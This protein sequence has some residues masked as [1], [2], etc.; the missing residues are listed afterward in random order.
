MV[1]GFVKEYKKKSLLSALTPFFRGRIKYVTI[2]LLVAAASIPVVFSSDIF[3]KI[4]ETPPVAAALRA[5]GLG[6]FVSAANAG[7]SREFVK[8]V[9]DKAEADSARDSYRNKL[10]GALKPAPPCGSGCSDVSTLTMIKG[11][12]DIYNSEVGKAGKKYAASEDGTGAV[13]LKGE[14]DGDPRAGLGPYVNR[15]LVSNPAS[16]GDR[17]AGI[18][19][20]AINQAGGSIP[21]PGR[22]EK[23]PVKMQGRVSGFS[24]KDVRRKS[25]AGE[26][27]FGGKRPM[28]QLAETFSA[29]DFAVRSGNSA[30]ERKASY[31][32]AAYDGNYVKLGGMR[33]DAVSSVP[34]EGFVKTL[35]DD[36]AGQQL[37][38]DCARARSVQGEKISADAKEMDSL[39]QAG[40]PP[41][42]YGDIDPW[43]ARVAR[44][45][46]LCKDFNY[47]QSILARAC[48]ISEA[49][50][51]CGVYFKND[52]N[53][54]RIISKCDKP[55]IIIRMLMLLR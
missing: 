19:A 50:M 47:N 33:T 21:V 29:G 39:A 11:A 14:P 6:R 40:D 34:A 41:M 27:S 54:G 4:T 5:V 25:A 46:E 28:S 45:G 30:Y 52:K 51:D 44:Q 9:I 15:S 31:T 38:G 7:D 3:G 18:Y 55:N 12:A 20:D 13:D 49:P 2:L 53:G 35:D 1:K 36:L 48:Q 37:A 26:N 24:W 10:T 22:A 23:V 43:N 42:C 32:G 8:S 16:I 17:K